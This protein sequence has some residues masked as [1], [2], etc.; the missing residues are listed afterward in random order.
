MFM[1][2]APEL[3]LRSLD[4]F[5]VSVGAAAGLLLAL[6]CPRPVVRADRSQTIRERRAVADLTCRARSEPRQGWAARVDTED[7]RDSQRVAAVL[8]VAGVGTAGGC[9]EGLIV[10]AQR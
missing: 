3:S 6:R 9:D 4:D 1:A 2:T 8:A 7:R 10:R 5:R